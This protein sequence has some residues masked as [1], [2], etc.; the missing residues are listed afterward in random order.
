MRRGKTRT[1]DVM[2]YGGAITKD[3]AGLLDLFAPHCEDRETIDWLRSALADRGKWQKAHGVFTQIR[4]KSVK[5]GRSR[6]SVAMAQY[7]FEEICAKT[8]YNLCSASAPFDADSPY[9][10]VPNAIAFARRLGMKEQE[11]L[12]CVTSPID[13]LL[14]LESDDSGA[15]RHDV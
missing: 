14:A 2:N 4:S 9:W 5:A 13:W 8:L 11:V 1:L 3:M 7:L 6:N 15:H 10:L 12:S